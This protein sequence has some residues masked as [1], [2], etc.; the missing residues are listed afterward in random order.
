MWGFT[1][2]PHCLFKGCSCSSA[3]QAELMPGCVGSGI[4]EQTPMSP[5]LFV[6]A[7][8]LHL[9][10]VDVALCLQLSSPPSMHTLC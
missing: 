6:S 5:L 8:L 4:C 2:V 1:T 3:H 10:H 9:H 7:E